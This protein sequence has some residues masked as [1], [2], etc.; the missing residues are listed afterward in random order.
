MI[1]RKTTILLLLFIAISASAQPGGGGGLEILNVLDHDG[2]IISKKDTSL[3]IQHYI[4][5]NKTYKVINEYSMTGRERENEKHSAFIYLPDYIIRKNKRI[6]TANQRLTLIYKNDTMTIDF[7]D[8]RQENGAGLTDIMEQ[9]WFQ[10]GYFKCYLRPQKS[11]ITRWEEI[12]LTSKQKNEMLHLLEQGIVPS[13]LFRLKT[14]GLIEHIP[15][16]NLENKRLR[17]ERENCQGSTVGKYV[18]LC[19]D[20]INIDNKDSTINISTKLLPTI[21]D[22][23]DYLRFLYYFQF[24]GWFGVNNPETQLA[25]YTLVKLI[26]YRIKMNGRFFSGK[27]KFAVFYNRAGISRTYS[28]YMVYE[29][30]YQDGKLLKSTILNDVNIF[31]DEL[32][33]RVLD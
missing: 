26:S 17:R 29:N 5:S 18:N 33:E 27:I 12:N 4:L 15:D 9:V 32:M 16:P 3:K 28:K 30:S 11:H 2:N 14:V 7:I 23:T 20:R 1:L 19:Y 31:T 22:S 6:I 10:S 21:I 25:N 24:D 8:I 13:T